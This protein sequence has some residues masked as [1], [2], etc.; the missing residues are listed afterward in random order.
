MK[1]SSLQRTTGS[2][3]KINIVVTYL[4]NVIDNSILNV[5]HMVAHSGRQRVIYDQIN[6]NGLALRM[7]KDSERAKSAVNVY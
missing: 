7:N 5:Q 1:N 2:T 4:R 6:V 3:T